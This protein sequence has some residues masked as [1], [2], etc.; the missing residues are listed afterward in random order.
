MTQTKLLPEFLS[1]LADPTDSYVLVG[2]NV[3][4]PLA[5]LRVLNQP[6]VK[7]THSAMPGYLWPSNEPMGLDFF[8]YLHGYLFSE[9]SRDEDSSLSFFYRRRVYYRIRYKL[10]NQTE[11]TDLTAEL[12]LLISEDPIVDSLLIITDIGTQISLPYDTLEAL[13]LPRGETW[14]KHVEL[15]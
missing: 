15:V 14:R 8:L 5:S 4:T 13:V 11:Y 6:E 10:S 12:V 2:V 9:A 3:P 1:A 7:W